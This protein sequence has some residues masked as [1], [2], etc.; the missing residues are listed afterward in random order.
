MIIPCGAS[1]F[2]PDNPPVSGILGAAKYLP[3]KEEIIG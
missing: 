2:R 3:F 1:V